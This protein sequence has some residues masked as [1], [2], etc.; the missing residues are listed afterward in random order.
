MTDETPVPTVAQFALLSA[1]RSGRLRRF[2]YINSHVDAVTGGLMGGTGGK[3]PAEKLAPL[4]EAGWLTA[5][6]DTNVNFD[7]SWQLTAAGIE[8][9]SR[10]L[11]QPKTKRVK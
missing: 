11:A 5:P 2:Y 1:A 7:A 6:T 10:Y 4:A 9:R 3:V 8:A